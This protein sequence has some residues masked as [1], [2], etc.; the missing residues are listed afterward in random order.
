MV[1]SKPDVI[2]NRLLAALPRKDRMHMLAGC[3]RVTLEAPQLIYEAEK[4]IQFV[5]FPL[6]C[7]ASVIASTHGKD[8][9]EVGMIGNEGMVG[10]PLLMSMDVPLLD[11]MI[12]G[13]GTALRMR[14]A[15]FKRELEYSSALRRRLQNYAYV[16]MRQL[17][18]ATTCMR[19][20]L[21]EER[22]AR[23]LLMT[24]DRAHS[25]VLHLTQEFLSYMLGV[26]RVGIS[27]AATSLQQRGLISYSRGEIRILDREGLIEAACRCYRADIEYYANVLEKPHSERTPHGQHRGQHAPAPSS[28]RMRKHNV[29]S[30]S[31]P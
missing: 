3:E 18:Q 21:V 2:E 11:V 10:A 23:W 25:D 31:S 28:N 12:Q 16:V 15:L 24:Q 19:F 30:G 27:K 5:Y 26:R 22:L 9:L 4:R 6:D 20:H 14:N 1:I 7:F 29:A 17:A 8:R 13:T